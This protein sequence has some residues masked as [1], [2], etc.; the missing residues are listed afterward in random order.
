MT[1]YWLSEPPPQRPAAVVDDPD[2][3]VVG[4][5]VTGCA[6]ALRLAQAGKR[7]R[8]YD[9]RGVAEGASGRNG[10]F[11]LRGHARRRS[12]SRPRRSASRA[13]GR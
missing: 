12:T 9:A 11:A 5:G 7:V 6:A 13:P 2:V 4:A 8:L 10:G 3:V 1:S